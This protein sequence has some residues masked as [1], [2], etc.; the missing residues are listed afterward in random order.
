MQDLSSIHVKVFVYVSDVPLRKNL[1]VTRA[2]VTRWHNSNI[3]KG[4]MRPHVNEKE[5]CKEEVILINPFVLEWIPNVS[6]INCKGNFKHN[7]NRD[8]CLTDDQQRK[9][10]SIANKHELLWPLVSRKNKC[11]QDLRPWQLINYIHAKDNKNN[12]NTKKYQ[13]N[14][15]NL[16]EVNAI[17]RSPQAT[18][19][20]DSVWGS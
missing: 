20:L 13:V 10:W 14:D 6:N 9:W 1:G 19:L 11:F 12:C 5:N 15:E 4:I 16:G 18:I 17:F 2:C 3:S 8:S 7:I